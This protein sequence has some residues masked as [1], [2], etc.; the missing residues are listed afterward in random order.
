LIHRSI[1]QSIYRSIDPSI[2]QSFFTGVIDNP[3]VGT[4]LVA[5]VNVLATWVAQLLM[6]SC[7]RRTLLL[8]SAGG[9][10]VSLS[11]LTL[12]LMGYLPRAGAYIT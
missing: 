7:G 3:L 9:M 4:T 8:W 11:G 1:D 6:D 12:A 10:L 2:N 5:A